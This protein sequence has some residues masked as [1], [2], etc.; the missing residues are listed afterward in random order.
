MEP[1]R[2]YLLTKSADQNIL[3]SFES[4]SSCVE[5]LAEF[6]D[7]ALQLSYDPWSNV[8]FHGR[9]KI[10]ADLTKSYEDVKGLLLMLTRMVM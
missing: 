7:R 1:L 4:N 6:G 10:H 8:K 3:L 5:M 9:A 2:S